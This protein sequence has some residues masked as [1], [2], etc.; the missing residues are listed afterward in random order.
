MANPP[1]QKGTARET[2]L[3]PALSLVWPDVAR[4]PAMTESCDFINTGTWTIEA[5]HAKAWQIMKWIRKVRAVAD[6]EWAI[7]IKHGAM[8]TKEGKSVGRVVVIDE[9]LFIRMAQV[10]ESTYKQ[11]MS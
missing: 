3:I 10:Y 9:D 2:A 11:G 5:K 7:M 4:S 1:K 6:G 8:N